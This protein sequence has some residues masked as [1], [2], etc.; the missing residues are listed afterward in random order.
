MSKPRQKEII[1]APP[2]DLCIPI[3]G[4]KALKAINDETLELIKYGMDKHY[5]EDLIMEEQ[6]THPKIWEELKKLRD[7]A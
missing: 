2:I 3:L 5:V 7:I 1:D 6:R 4:A